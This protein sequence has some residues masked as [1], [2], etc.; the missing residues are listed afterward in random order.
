MG[1]SVGDDLVFFRGIYID[2]GFQHP[3]LKVKDCITALGN[4]AKWF[5]VNASGLCLNIYFETGRFIESTEFGF[6]NVRS[7]VLFVSITCNELPF[8]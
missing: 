1:C 2:I 7:R 8:K 4:T 3:S 5:R 6:R